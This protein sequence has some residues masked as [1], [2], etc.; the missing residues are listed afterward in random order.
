M[1]AF[2]LDDMMMAVDTQK[3]SRAEAGARPDDGDDA[4]VRKQYIGPAQMGERVLAELSHGMRHR[5]ETVEAEQPLQSQRRCQPPRPQRPGT[6]G[7]ITT[8]LPG[9]HPHGDTGGGGKRAAEPRARG[10][11]G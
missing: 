8:G 6:A 10:G 3:L 7:E 9:L 11:R 5:T 2:R 4:L 1:A